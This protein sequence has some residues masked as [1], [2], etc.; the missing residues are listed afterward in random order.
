M[1]EL[2]IGR[3]KILYNSLYLR[4]DLGCRE[5]DQGLIILE[6]LRNLIYFICDVRQVVWLQGWG[7]SCQTPWLGKLGLSSGSATAGSGNI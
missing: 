1:H 2:C 3:R 5:R 7:L 6:V 4:L